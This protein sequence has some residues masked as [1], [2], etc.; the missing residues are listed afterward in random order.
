[1]VFLIAF[2][3]KFKFRHLYLTAI[4]L[5]ICRFTV[6]AIGAP[7]YFIV[8]FGLTRGVTWGIHGY[9]WGQFIVHITG[10]KNSTLAIMIAAMI[11]NA[12][13]ATLKIFMGKFIVKYGYHTFYLIILYVLIFSFIYFFTV[14]HNNDYKNADSQEKKAL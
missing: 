2:R 10:K 1:M 9:L 8:A 7:I 14:Y 3:K 11:I 12:Y 4:T 5:S 13:Q 6:S